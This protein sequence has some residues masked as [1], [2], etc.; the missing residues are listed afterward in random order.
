MNLSR[1]V[2]YWAARSPSKVAI[3]FE[4][5]DYTYA[6][7][8][9]QVGSAANSLAVQK[10]ERVAWLGYNNPQMLVLLF[11]LARLGAILVPLNWRLTVAEHREIVAD[12]APRLL[13]CDAEFEQ[14]ASQL[15]VPIGSLAIEAKNKTEFPGDE[16]DDALIVYTSGTTGKPKGAVL[17]QAALVWHA[18]NSLHAHA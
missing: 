4:G 13:F 15:G 2:D 18:L 3:H 11:A 10:G 8:A 12:C 6:E 17:T 9:I 16:A 14:H 1:F 5:K 7:L